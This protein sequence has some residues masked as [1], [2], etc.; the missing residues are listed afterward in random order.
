LNLRGVLQQVLAG[1]SKRAGGQCS[2][3]LKH[4]SAT[5]S[6]RLRNLCDQRLLLIMQENNY[7]S[8]HLNIMN[9]P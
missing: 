1:L 3:L 5:F 6:L 7:K 9:Y 8:Y 2:A 4:C